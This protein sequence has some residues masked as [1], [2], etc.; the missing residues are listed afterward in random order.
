MAECIIELI[1][2]IGFIIWAIYINLFY[3]KVE[4]TVTEGGLQSFD[5]CMYE[6]QGI[7][8]ESN[9]HTLFPKRAGKKE[10]IWVCKNNPKKAITNQWYWLGLSLGIMM[11]PACIYIM[12]VYY[13]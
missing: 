4:G 11:V 9:A 13:L 8:Y 3:A 10:K 12:Y 6:F 5:M 1:F 7:K 2:G